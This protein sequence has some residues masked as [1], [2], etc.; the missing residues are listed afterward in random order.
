MDLAVLRAN[1][2]FSQSSLSSKGIEAYWPRTPKLFEA[3]SARAGRLS[4]AGAELRK[5][6]GGTPSFNTVREQNR[7]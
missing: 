7:P 2:D 6:F 5:T 3:V 1:V 4:S